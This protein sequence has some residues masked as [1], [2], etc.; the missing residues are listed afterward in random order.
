[1]GE[2]RSSEGTQRWE[3]WW[4]LRRRRAIIADAQ[5]GLGV[6]GRPGAKPE[7]CRDPRLPLTCGDSA[8]K[9]WSKSGG[10]AGSGAVGLSTSGWEAS[11]AGGEEGGL[12]EQEAGPGQYN[13]WSGCATLSFP[14][15]CTCSAMVYNKAGFGWNLNDVV[16]FLLQRWC[17]G[18]LRCEVCGELRREV[19]PV[20]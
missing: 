10:T 19:E 20:L 11:G 15:S 4:W 9:K 2:R 6:V 3:D 1:M 8:L 13:R 5:A 14:R 18:L 17:L 12:V 16:M 7:A